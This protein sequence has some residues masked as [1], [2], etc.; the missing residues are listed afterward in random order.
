MVVTFYLDDIRY[1]RDVVITN[2]PR[3]GETVHLLC[4]QIT[5]VEQIVWRYDKSPKG[6]WID[7]YLKRV[8]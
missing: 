2:L 1:D 5:M 8:K 6:D 3:V 4:G 7:I